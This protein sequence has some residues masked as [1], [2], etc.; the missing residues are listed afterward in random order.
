[1]FV[2]DLLHKFELGV[3]K[4]VFIHLMRILYAAGGTVVQQL[5]YRYL[6]MK[7]VLTL[8]EFS[9]RYRR[10]PPFG[11]GTIRQ[12]HKNASAMKRLAGWDFEDLLQVCSKDPLVHVPLMMES[13]VH[14]PSSRVS[15]Q[16]SITT[17]FSTF[18][19]TSQHGT[20][21]LSYVFIPRR[22]SHSLMQPLSILASQSAGFNVR[23]ASIMSQLS[24]HKNMQCAVAAQ[25]H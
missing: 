17:S 5:N 22:L 11:R 23:R 6:H 2:I 9:Y 7:L 8:T 10:V 15:C 16:H 25:P 20:R 14:C 12:F 19:S 21:S 1:M 18:S 24:F 13:S 3:W 4:G